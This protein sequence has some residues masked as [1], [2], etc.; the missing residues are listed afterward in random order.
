MSESQGETITIKKETFWKYA[1]FALAAFLV[2][3]AFVFFNNNSPTG[4]VIAPNPASPDGKVDV[5][6]GDSPVLG[7]ANAPVT[8][9]EFSDYECPFCG[10]FA[11]QTLP[12]IKSEYVDTGKVK[13][14]FKDFPLTSIHPFALSAAE[15]A[16]CVGEQGG[17]EAY[18][19]M[20]D[21]IFDN[22]AS[23]STSNLKIWAKELGYDIDKCL[24]S[25]KHRDA[26]LKDASQAQ[27]AGV[28]GTPHFLINGKSLSGAQPFSAFKQAIDAELA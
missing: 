24:D 19:K 25:G 21:K 27:A 16:R 23:L 22:Q 5:P 11:K 12:L 4:N 20:H 28:R 8:I 1:T 26:A 14:V 15:A 3:G 17:D 9:I 6:I 10:S 13:I 7:D 2:I 18:F